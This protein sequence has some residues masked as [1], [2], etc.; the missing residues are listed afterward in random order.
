[1]AWDEAEDTMTYRVLI[2]EDSRTYAMLPDNQRPAAGWKDAGVRGQ[3]VECLKYV[4]KVWADV[5]LLSLPEIEVR[6]RL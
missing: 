6:V 4:Q 3:K 2:S 5:R 1:M